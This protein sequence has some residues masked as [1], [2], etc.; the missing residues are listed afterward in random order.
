MVASGDPG[1][2]CRTSD[3]VTLA[4]PK[5]R[6]V[7]REPGYTVA[8]QSTNRAHVTFT[9]AASAH[10]YLASQEPRLAEQLHVIPAF[11]VAP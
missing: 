8:F 11:E 7:V 5:R 3:W 6:V 4:P 2:A 9:S 10:E 1:T